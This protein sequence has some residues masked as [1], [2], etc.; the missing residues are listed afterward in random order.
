MNPSDPHSSG[1]APEGTWVPDVLGD[2]WESRE[3]RLPPDR[4]GDAVATLVRPTTQ[5]PRRT[6]AVLYVHGFVD[7]FFH[8]HLA[9]LWHTLDRDFFAIDL[10]GYGRSMGD[11]P[12]N[13]VADI[14]VHAQDLDAALRVL[15]NELGYQEVVVNGH[16]TGGLIAPLWAAARASA[17][18]RSVDALVLNSPWL[19]LNKGWFDRE[20]TTQL[21]RPLARLAPDLKVGS[22]T[23]HYCEWLADPQGG[24]WTFD[25]AWKPPA[26]FPVHAGWLNSVR[27]GHRAVARGLNL[28]VP[29]LVCTSDASGSAEHWHDAL[30]RTDS[31][32]SVEQMAR[33]APGLGSDV[34]LVEIP[35][36]VHDLALS[37]PAARQAYFD[38]VTDWVTDRLGA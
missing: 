18:D 27:R 1:S 16:S 6:R 26:G 35:G 37:L 20:I 34:T 4:Y 13:A 30:D 12:P 28:D 9:D 17:D 8:P 25:Q 10:R 22:L 14:A 32:L 21:L 36:G 11:R 5:E 7:Y 29:I 33:R 38:A 24:G 15:R 23:E 3:L 19:D 31:V 2:G